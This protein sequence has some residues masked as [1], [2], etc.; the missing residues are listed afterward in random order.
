[1]KHAVNCQSKGYSVS[2][3]RPVAKNLERRRLKCA[4]VNVGGSGHMQKKFGLKTSE[5]VKNYE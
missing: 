5:N 1:M 2:N 4:L 3:T